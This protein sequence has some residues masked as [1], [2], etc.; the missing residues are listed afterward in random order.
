MGFFNA[1]WEAL[2]GLSTF[3]PSLGFDRSDSTQHPL[4]L[5]GLVIEPEHASPGF[6]C[7]YPS[8]EA[9]GFVSCNTPDSRDCWLRNPG[10]KQPLWSEWN[11]HT[12]CKFYI[13]GVGSGSRQLTPY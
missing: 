8:L 2:L 3:A 9:E 13:I 4:P 10:Y 11:I 7:S 1:C 6:Q 12:D 5:P